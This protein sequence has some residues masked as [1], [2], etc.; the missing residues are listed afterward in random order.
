[1]VIILV[2]SA[3]STLQGRTSAATTANGQFAEI[4]RDEKQRRKMDWRVIVEKEF[5][6]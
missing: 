5:L 2:V 1:M 6:S 4:L 3:H